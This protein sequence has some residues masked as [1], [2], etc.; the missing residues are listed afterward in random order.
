LKALLVLAPITGM[1]KGEILSRKWSDID[2]DSGNVANGSPN[3][4]AKNNPTTLIGKGIEADDRPE[5]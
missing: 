5:T 2:L 1:R 4:K 3:P